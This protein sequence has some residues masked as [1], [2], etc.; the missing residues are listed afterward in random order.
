V[1]PSRAPSQTKK[2][3]IGS[4]DPYLVRSGNIPL[5]TTSNEESFVF[6]TILCRWRGK[7]RDQTTPI[8]APLPIY[9]APGL[10][11][12][13]TQVIGS[14][15]ILPCNGLRR[16]F[17]PS[18]GR[19]SAVLRKSKHEKSFFARSPGGVTVHHHSLRCGTELRSQSCYL[20]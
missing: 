7:C 3:G 17:Q 18:F 6:F 13:V 1:N 4:H 5:R 9:F 10:R 19:S 8:A 20:P 12:G 11:P 15:D 14:K 16:P 2:A